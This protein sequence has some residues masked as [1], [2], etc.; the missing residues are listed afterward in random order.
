MSWRPDGYTSV[1]PYQMVRDAEATLWFLE[2]V[3]G[4][5]RLRVHHREA[6]VDIAHAKAR[7]DDTVVMIG[8]MPDA[9]ETHLHVYVV[10]AEAAFDRALEAGGTT[11]LEFR[12]SGDSDHRGGMADANGAV[13]WISTQDDGAV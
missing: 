4:V 7:V 11:V 10:D 8:E 5:E 6:G 12:R 9:G 3:F 2:K 1:S 13:W